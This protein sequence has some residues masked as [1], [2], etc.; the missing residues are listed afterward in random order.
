MIDC[1]LAR[2]LLWSPPMPKLLDYYAENKLAW[3]LPILIVIGVI[4][5]LAMT[6]S[7]V[8]TD[9]FDYRND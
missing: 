1:A 3:I 6:E 7:N 2:P 5:Y 8:P 9:P 4:V